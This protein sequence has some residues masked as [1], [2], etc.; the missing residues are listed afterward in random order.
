MYLRIIVIFSFLVLFILSLVVLFLINWICL[1]DIVEFE[2]LR[3][4]RLFFVMILIVL[5]IIFVYCGLY[6]LNDIFLRYYYVF[7]VLIFNND[8]IFI[9][10]LVG[11][12]F[13]C[14]ICL[15]FDFIKMCV[16]LLILFCLSY[17]F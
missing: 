1:Y 5:L 4:W 2:Y 16:F 9:I 11:D 3:V 13:W 8:V 12:I 6:C 15:F 17:I 10:C 14:V 7:N